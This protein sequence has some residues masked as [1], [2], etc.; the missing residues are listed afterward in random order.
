VE[1]DTESSDWTHRDELI[2]EEEV[3][4]PSGGIQFGSLVHNVLQRV[5]FSKQFD[6][7]AIRGW[8]EHLAPLYVYQDA[9]GAAKLA[10]ELIGRLAESPRGLAMSRAPQLRR[11][12][13]FLLNWTG[14]RYLQGYIDAVYQGDDGKWRI[15]DYKS[16]EV[17]QSRIASE[18]RRYEMQLYVYALAIERALGVSPAELVLY[19]LRPGE[20][21]VFPWNDA[22]RKQV[23]EMVDRAL[24]ASCLP[25]ER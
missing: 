11:E 24:D 19:F 18:A 3:D 7:D 2:V 25:S 16:N 10:A 15:V 5:D 23:Q 17:S 13:E 20:E 6:R 4:G 9:A 8:C 14:G 22:A 12:V 21:Y 1:T